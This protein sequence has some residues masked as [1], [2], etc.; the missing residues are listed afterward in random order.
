MDSGSGDRWQPQC[1]GAEAVCSRR[2]HSHM[3]TAHFLLAS[4]M[5]SRR[6]WPRSL[7]SSHLLRLQCFLC[8]L[9]SPAEDSVRRLFRAGRVFGR[10]GF[11]APESSAADPS[12]ADMLMLLEEALRSE[13]HTELHPHS[14]LSLQLLF[15]LSDLCCLSVLFRA[16]APASLD[17]SLHLRWLLLELLSCVSLS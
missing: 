8:S 16:E 3:F 4:H 12:Q 14:R 9:W 2:R 17:S 15:T 7:S 13:R 5:R 1:R 11:T 10:T 6:L